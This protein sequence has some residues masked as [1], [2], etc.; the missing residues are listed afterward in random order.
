MKSIALY[1]T[2]VLNSLVFLVACA[3]SAPQ[4]KQPAVVEDRTIVDGEVL[5]LPDQPKLSAQTLGTA[6]AM[7]PVAQR[8]LDK[9]ELQR[10][11]GDM[12]A[13]AGSLER[14]LRIEPRNALLWSRLAYIRYQQGNWQQ[15]AQL[16]MKSN[17]LNPSNIDLR[18]ENWYLMANAYQEMGELE[19]AKLYRSKLNQASQ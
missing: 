9:S 4:P 18:R 3:T 11:D 14:A 16:A 7:S 13:A 12:V 1:K 10:R 6:T 8:L 17:T 5:P 15:S 2:V 19:K